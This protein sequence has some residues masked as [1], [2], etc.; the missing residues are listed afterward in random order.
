VSGT[1]KA[2]KPS[3]ER[4]QGFLRFCSEQEIKDGTAVLWLD[5]DLGT[6][7]LLTPGL[8]REYLQREEVE[9]EG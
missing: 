4:L 6:G 7:Y 8:A 1:A 9:D 5:H 3:K 2:D